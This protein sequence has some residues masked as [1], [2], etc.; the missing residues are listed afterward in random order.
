MGCAR[1]LIHMKCAFALILMSFTARVIFAQEAV[2]LE[3]A[4]KAARKVT[5]IAVSDPPFKMEVDVDQSSA[6]KADKGGLLIV[7]DKQLTA[8]KLATSGAAIVPIG[9]LWS[10][11]VSLAANGKAIGPDKLRKV[12]VTDGD[13]QRELELYFLGAG[14]NERGEL[15]LIVFGKEKESVLRVPLAK[16]DGASAQ[17]LPI[18]LTGRKDNEDSGT[19]TLHLVDKYT[20]DL[21]VVRNAEQ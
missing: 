7:P 1:I 17:R 12:S 8:E 20:A 18:S 2:P 21:P 6:I 13:K 4:Q 3:D 5:E 10:L 15:E 11:R 14:K 16:T 19:L 9:Q